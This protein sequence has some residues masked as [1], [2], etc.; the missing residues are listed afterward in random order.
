MAAIIETGR[1]LN[2]LKPEVVVP[3]HAPSNK[4]LSPSSIEFTRR[5]IKAF[6]AKMKEAPDAAALRVEMSR[7]YPD[8]AMPFCLE[9]S[10]KILKKSLGLGRSVAHLTA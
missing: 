8:A 1:K 6:A 7:I 4:Y 10:S 2:A 3:G 9:Y 5:H